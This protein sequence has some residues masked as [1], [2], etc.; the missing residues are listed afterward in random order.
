MMEINS[1]A[2]I[3]G[4][5]RGALGVSPPGDLSQ[6]FDLG[7]APRGQEDECLP[8]QGGGAFGLFIV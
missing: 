2:C 5:S 6:A 8:V 7:K 3:V 1:G 4:G